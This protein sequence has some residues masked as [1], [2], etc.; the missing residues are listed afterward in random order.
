MCV[1]SF[2]YMPADGRERDIYGEEGI[3]IA[4][5]HLPFCD[6]VFWAR[7]ESGRRRADGQLYR[8]KVAIVRVLIRV[9]LSLSMWC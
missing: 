5:Y 6:F 1:V 8:K 7:D 4:S 3:E 2:L 9:S